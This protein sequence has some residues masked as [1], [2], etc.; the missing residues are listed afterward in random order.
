MRPAKQAN[1]GGLRRGSPARHRPGQPQK[2][3]RSK[4][5]AWHSLSGCSGSCWW[6]RVTAVC[7][8]SDIDCWATPWPRPAAPPAHSGLWEHTR[9]CL[10]LLT[11]NVSAA[12]GSSKRM[13][14][15]GGGRRPAACSSAQLQLSTGLSG[16]QESSTGSLR[17]EWVAGEDAHI[18]EFACLCLSAPPS[19]CRTASALPGLLLWPSPRRSGPA[20]N[21]I[22]LQGK[23]CP[24]CCAVKQ[25]GGHRVYKHWWLTGYCKCNC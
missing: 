4:F 10:W 13:R 11:P 17:S 15:T 23:L 25:R 5:G 9:A 3:L 18:Q 20:G 1:I 16:V 8:L 12:R 6:R 2:R 21:Y 14:I 24:T 22:A 19:P 7:L